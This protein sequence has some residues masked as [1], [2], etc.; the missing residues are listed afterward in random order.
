MSLEENMQLQPTYGSREEKLMEIV[1][2]KQLV[3]GGLV[4]AQTALANT[5]I[6]DPED[7]DDLTQAL[8][9]IHFMRESIDR[10]MGHLFTTIQRIGQNNQADAPEQL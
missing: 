7:N 8:E 5:V 3:L 10:S 9:V 1:S 6:R 4:M 2:T